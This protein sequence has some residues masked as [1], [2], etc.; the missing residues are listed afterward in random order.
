M[1][2]GRGL[3]SGKGSGLCSGIS[4]YSYDNH[5]SLIIIH[6]SC[7]SCFTVGGMHDMF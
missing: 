5:Y 1:S 3:C 6:F 2:K 4:I 7:V